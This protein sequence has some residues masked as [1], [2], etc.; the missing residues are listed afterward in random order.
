MGR[1]KG[2]E[3][4]GILFF[5]HV[6]GLTNTIIHTPHFVLYWT[7]TVLKT[8]L[9]CRQHEFLK[10]A[11]SSAAAG[12]VVLVHAQDNNHLARLCQDLKENITKHCGRRVR[13]LTAVYEK[14]CISISLYSVCTVASAPM[15]SLSSR[16]EYSSQTF[17]KSGHPLW[18]SG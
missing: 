1:G 13:H 10:T 7:Q 4:I 11:L 2:Y 14:L 5:I 12:D 9:A 17:T 16:Y 18:P 8:M 15:T 6:Y 3:N